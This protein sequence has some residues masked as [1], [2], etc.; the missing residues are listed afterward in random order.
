MM[1]DQSGAGAAADKRALETQFRGIALNITEAALAA[2]II[3]SANTGE[4]GDHGN[5]L[6]DLYAGILKAVRNQG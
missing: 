6:G 3:P 2:G 1:H 5:A 4:G